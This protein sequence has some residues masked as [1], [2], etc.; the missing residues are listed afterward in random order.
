MGN[1]FVRTLIIGITMLVAAFYVYPTV[2]WMMLD[3]S[4]RD[5]RLEAWKDEDLA[6]RG[7]DASIVTEA[8]WAIKRWMEFDRDKVITLGLDLQGGVHMVAGFEMTEEARA[9]ELTEGDVQDMIVE[10]IRNRIS[11]LEVRE[12]IIQKQGTNQ[13]QVQLPGEQDV[14]RAIELIQRTAYLAFHIAP[15]DAAMIDSF[16]KIDRAYGNQFLPFLEPP[17]P[18]SGY[19]EVKPENFNHIKEIADEVNA[20]P[21]ESSLLPSATYLGERSMIA[22]SP[23]PN[24]WD[25]NSNYLVYVI[26]EKEAINGEG[27][28]R[29]S[30]LP[31]QQSPGSW[32]ISFEFGG[33]AAQEFAAMTDENKGR[34]MAIVI[35]GFVLSA[36]VIEERI[37]GSGVIRGS[38]S[39]EEARDLAISL[40][41]GSLPLE[42]TPDYTGIVGP[43]LGQESV[44]RGVKSS[45][46]G[47]AIVMVFMIVYYRAAGVLANISLMVNA[48][49]IVGAFAYFKVTLTLPGIAG[50]ILTI[51]MAV[52]ANVIIFERIREELRLG[53]ALNGAVE[54]GFEKATS[55]ILDANVTTLIAAA[56]LSQF[57]TGPVQGFAVALS[58]GIVTSVFAALV[59]TR[60]QFDFLLARKMMGKLS[61]TSIF[62]ATPSF[63]F[64][65]KRKLAYTVSGALIVVGLV[66]V[67]IR[68]SDVLGVDFT[69]GTTATIDIISENTIVEGEVRTLLESNGFAG[70]TVQFSQEAGADIGNQFLIRLAESGDSAD[71]TPISNRIQSALASLSAQGETGVELLR[72][73]SIG[74]AVGAKLQ[75]DAAA[76]MLFALVFIMLY[77]WF[78]FEF[79]FAAGAAFALVHDV[80]IVGGLMALLGR[81][82]TLPMVAAL[83]TIIGYSLNDTIIVF[84][85]VREDLALSR[86]KGMSL[87][88]SMNASLNRTLSRTVLTSLTTFFVVLVLFLYGGPAINDFALALMLGVIVGTYSSIFVAAPIVL[89]LQRRRASIDGSGG[90]DSGDR[91]K[92]KPG[93]P[94]TPGK[95]VRERKRKL[96]PL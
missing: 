95:G 14:E 87:I 37:F 53:K 27:L 22:F 89:A 66:F 68:G 46:I 21:A 96:Q 50:L 30:E 45:L 8:G 48:L 91:A 78:R 11:E 71:E 9:R 10:N 35:D 19:F 64:L 77:L 92:N 29:A 2:G 55:A 18:L 81:Q 15:S 69:N 61:M 32:N 1:H 76:A 40:N 47:L 23:Q 93:E 73:E 90:D 20:M 28:E 63:T 56:V 59:V 82:L 75:R 54:L 24:P 44:E 86:A 74:P 94:T 26:D 4:E 43:V 49:L 7:S 16:Q 70:P 12:P 58:I 31:D 72:V 25:E 62:P 33:A 88:E 36:P 60:A 13:I 52:D 39:G 3:R 42:I 41:S 65:E 67:G 84:D 34:N 51:G 79:R 83:L 38:F 5:A 6:R 17:G 80:L 85:R 57:G